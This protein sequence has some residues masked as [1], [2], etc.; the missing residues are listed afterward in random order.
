MTSLQLMYSKRVSDEIPAEPIVLPTVN[1][2]RPGRKRKKL[3]PHCPE[4]IGLLYQDSPDGALLPRIVIPRILKTDIRRCYT[5]MYANVYNSCDWVLAQGFVTRFFRP[6]NVVIQELFGSF[7]SKLRGRYE[8]HGVP[9]VAQYWY[10]RMHDWPDVR[11]NIKEHAIKIST[12]YS[13]VISLKFSL[14]GTQFLPAAEPVVNPTSNKYDPKHDRY[15]MVF[16]EETASEEVR[17]QIESICLAPIMGADEMANCTLDQLIEVYEKLDKEDEERD[18]VLWRERVHYPPPPPAVPLP[19]PT[20][21]T[22]QVSL[23]A[24][25][26]E[27]SPC[28]QSVYV[29]FDGLIHLHFDT[30]SLIYLMEFYLYGQ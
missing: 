4:S 13:G 25:L 6:D 7:P 11:F 9:V 20:P 10:E 16:G 3:I 23:V 29:S 30:D 26:P 27:P 8:L 24:L 12:D 22:S 18:Q 19:P 21:P 17:E 2:N 28:I 5:D 14:S 15:I 1:R